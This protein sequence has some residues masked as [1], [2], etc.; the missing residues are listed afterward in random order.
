M[1]NLLDVIVS[2]RLERAC[3]HLEA[4][5][6]VELHERESHGVYQRR[7]GRHEE[8]DAVTYQEYDRGTHHLQRNGPPGRGRQV[9][10]K[11]RHTQ[12]QRVE[13]QRQ[14]ASRESDGEET[15]VTQH[16]AQQSRNV[17]VGIPQTRAEV[18]EDIL[19]R[20]VEEQHQ[21]H[22]KTRHRQEC[23]RSHRKAGNNPRLVEQ[24]EA[25]RQTARE[26]QQEPP[27]RTQRMTQAEQARRHADV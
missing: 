4:G 3:T 19:A 8:V 11:P 2:Q 14:H 15:D 27:E 26:D 6:L 24:R 20:R 7:Y 9:A 23:G 1:F 21:H 18:D 25:R 10:V 16:V 13:H 22:A 17:V 12:R 5:V